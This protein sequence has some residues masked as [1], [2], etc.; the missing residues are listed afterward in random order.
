MI[1]IAGGVAEDVLHQERH[2]AERAVGQLTGSGQR[3]RLV[4]ER[5]DHRVELAV[6]ALDATD[7]RVDQLGSARLPAPHEV[8]LRGR[9]E[10]CQF[11]AHAGT[12]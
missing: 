3:A 4:E 11:V 1:R 10:E 9:V 6:H 8:R 5:H 12:L 2:A 7:R